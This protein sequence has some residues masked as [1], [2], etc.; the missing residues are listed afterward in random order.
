M[1]NTGRSTLGTSMDND[2]MQAVMRDLREA[3]EIMAGTEKRRRELGDVPTKLQ[4]KIEK[5]LAEVTEKLR[6]LTG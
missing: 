6:R 1:R 4:D 5:N 3:G 2:R